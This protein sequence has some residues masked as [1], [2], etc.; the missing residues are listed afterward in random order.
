[1]CD[2]GSAYAKD[3]ALHVYYKDGEIY[4]VQ[5]EGLKPTRVEVPPAYDQVRSLLQ[6]NAYR[7][8]KHASRPTVTHDLS[9]R[10]KPAHERVPERTKA[11]IEPGDSRRDKRSS[12]RKTKAKTSH[13]K[14]VVVHEDE[15][16]PEPALAPL[17]AQ[18]LP[19]AKPKE[20]RGSLYHSDRPR[21]T[22]EYL[23]EERAPRWER[24]GKD[25]Q[26]KSGVYL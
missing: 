16:T 14:T 12:D 3:V 23:V 8:R 1:M 7:A 25:A 22:K 24:G 9:R 10:A 6:K 21:K 13:Y 2:T 15:V 26:R 5:H 11:V 19:E 17:P 4:A 18:S 20:R